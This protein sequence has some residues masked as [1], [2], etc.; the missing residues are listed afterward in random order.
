MENPRSNAVSRKL[1]T[2]YLLA[3][4][5]L[6]VSTQAL[7]VDT[8]GDGLTDDE[9]I[10]TYGTNPNLADTDGDGLLDGEEVALALDYPGLDP[11]LPDSDRDGV[12]DDDEINI[13]G[14]NPISID[15][16][17]DGLS[18]FSEIAGNGGDPTA[19]DTDSIEIKR[20]S[21]PS[22]GKRY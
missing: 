10:N 3:A 19:Y 20:C 5:L 15:T 21:D 9:E 14:T 7:A 1:L 12:N 11:L 8:D 4:L 22:G 18:D 2:K 13:H 16:D 17:G 6:G